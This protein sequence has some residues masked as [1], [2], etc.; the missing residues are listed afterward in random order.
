M[1]L[2][3]DINRYTYMERV[4]HIL[5]EYLIKLLEG[6][7]VLPTCTSR[8]HF[9]VESKESSRT[10]GPYCLK[11]TMTRLAFSAML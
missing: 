3:D 9:P 6:E 2:S 7:N 5:K 8:G 11:V 4:A 10:V 1:Q